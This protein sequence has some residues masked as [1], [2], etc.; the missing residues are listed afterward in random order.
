MSVRV[1]VRMSKV[2][3]TPTKV[4]VLTYATYVNCQTLANLAL[5]AD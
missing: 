1:N 3:H 5:Y 4:G 2:I